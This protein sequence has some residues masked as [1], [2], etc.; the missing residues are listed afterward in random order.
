MGDHQGDLPFHLFGLY[1]A[2]D[3][4]VLAGFLSV[5]AKVTHGTI[6]EYKD[7]SVSILCENQRT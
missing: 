1:T 7:E 6:E 3:R 2:W 4:N 5:P